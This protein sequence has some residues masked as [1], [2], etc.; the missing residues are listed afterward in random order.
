MFIDKEENQNQESPNPEM[1]GS[2]FSLNRNIFILGGGLIVVF[3][4]SVGL[5]IYLAK[6]EKKPIEISQNQVA[7]T[8]ELGSENATSTLWIGLP[9]DSSSDNSDNGV[10]ILGGIKGERLAFGNY[11]KEITEDA[12]YNFLDYSLPMNVKI[13]VINYYDVSRKISLDASVDALNENGFVL[14]D[15]PFATEANNFYSI[16][17][18]LSEKQIPAFVTSDFIL[19]Y[20]Q[21]I[22]K[23]V[24][25]EI[26]ANVFY[27]NLWSLNYKMYKIAK[28]RYERILAETGV[29]NDPI[30]EGARTELVYFAVA[31]KLLEPKEEQ[32]S[33]ETALNSGNVFTPTEANKFGINFPTYL[34]G[35]IAKEYNLINTAKVI[36]KSPVFLYERDYKDFQIPE[37][38]QN[39]ARLN[40]FYLAS[41]WANSLFPLYYNGDLCPD[42]LLDRDDWRVNMITAS[43]ITKDLSENQDIKNQWAVI[44]KILSFFTGLRGDLNYLY[45]EEKLK[46]LFGEEMDIENIFSLE[47]I[48][49]EN[50]FSALQKELIKIKFLEIEGALS[51]NNPNDLSKIGLKVLADP[52]WP[53]KYIFKKLNSP[54]SGEYFGEEKISSTVC[55]DSKERCKGIGLDIINIISPINDN[56]Y[57][58]INSDY[59]NYN[60]QVNFLK[61]QLNNFTVYNWHNNNFWVNFDISKKYLN[62]NNKMPIFMQSDIW[63]EKNVNT[64]LGAWV[65]LQ[66]PMDKFSYYIKRSERLGDYAQYNEYNYVEPNLKL[67]QEL[68]ANTIMLLDMLIALGITGDTNSVSTDLQDLEERLRGLEGVITKELNGEEFDGSDQKTIESFVKQFSVTKESLKELAI[69]FEGEKNNYKITEDISGVK[70]AIIVYLK[71]DK[72]VFALGPVFNYQEK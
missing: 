60:N 69:L 36:A 42:C 54:N 7:T 51:R 11:Y 15:N 67:V 50:N 26:E 27:D 49:R 40:N 13:D 47:N 70:L 72:K 6:S 45:Y 71:G 18:L 57:F 53:D 38:Y 44:Y 68:R 65:N 21:N 8:T 63:R 2:F 62:Y 31:L 52:Y 30:L 64:A 14:I 55:K 5:M 9:A 35:Q 23:K 61:Y 37:E 24:F 41:K 43:L 34:E 59:S 32:I 29:T 25:K 16:Y 39:N 10:I 17:D 48:E 28:A 19:Y 56:E 12:N 58:E 46:D 66:L 22:F 3:A 1:G 20:Q 33:E 4:L